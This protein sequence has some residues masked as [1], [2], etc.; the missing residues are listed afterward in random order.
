M[1]SF[2]DDVGIGLVVGG[3]RQALPDAQAWKMP[4]MPAGRI[5]LEDG[6]IFGDRGGTRRVAHRIEIGIAAPRPIASSSSRSTSNGMRIS[7]SGSDRRSRETTPSC[8]DGDRFSVRAGRDRGSVPAE[9][10]FEVD[11][12]ARGQQGLQRAGGFG[13]DL[14]PGARRDRR[15]IA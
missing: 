10:T 2:G 12:P 15:V 8:S 6:A 7:I 13:V 9:R 4:S 11:Q 5:A 3:N 1:R 14:L